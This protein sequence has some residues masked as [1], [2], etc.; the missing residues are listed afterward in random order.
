[1]RTYVDDW[2]GEKSRH[3]AEQNMCWT[4]AENKRR[5]KVLPSLRRNQA[6]WKDTSTSNTTSDGSGCSDSGT[7]GTGRPAPPS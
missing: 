4:S 7:V 2:A 6:D 1:M 3:Q 5:Q